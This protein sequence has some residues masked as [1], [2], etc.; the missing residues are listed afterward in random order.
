MEPHREESQKVSPPGAEQRPKRFRIV[1]LEDRIAPTKGG[2][3]SH[4]HATACGLGCPT[5]VNCTICCFGGT[6]Y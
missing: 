2:N 3:V 6:I 5:Y 4:G 1:K